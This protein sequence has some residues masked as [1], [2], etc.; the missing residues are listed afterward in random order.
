M[1]IT[2]RNIIIAVVFL[3]AVAL[4]FRPPGISCNS[5]EQGVELKVKGNK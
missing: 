4:L 5:G 3:I 1:S 2:V